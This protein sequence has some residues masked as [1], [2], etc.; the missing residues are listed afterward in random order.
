[1]TR[2]TK[3]ALA[4]GAGVLAAGVIWAL[5][6]KA[7]PA[8]LPAGPITSVTLGPGPSTQAFSV[9]VAQKGTISIVAPAGATLGTVSMSPSGLL[10][11]P[12]SGA[13]YE[14]VAAGVGTVNFS[15][16]YTDSTGAAQTSTFVVTVTA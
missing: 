7:H 14:Y 13:N 8:A 5:Y 16:S 1:M 9:S 3:T 15:A 6:Q 4:I 12:T 10:V 2:K 11:P